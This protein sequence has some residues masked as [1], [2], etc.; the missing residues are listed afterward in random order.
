M[1]NEYRSGKITPR[2]PICVDFDGV[3]H[4]YRKGFA[5]GSIYD[6]PVAGVAAAL[7]KLR[8]RYFIYV[9][10]SRTRNS[11]GRRAVLGYLRKYEI[12]FD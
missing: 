2:I 10:S 5:D 12:P 4:A 3:I 6:I 7:R 8:K 11:A 9:L 1:K